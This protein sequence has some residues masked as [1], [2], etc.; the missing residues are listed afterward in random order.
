ML[1]DNTGKELRVTARLSADERDI[2]DMVVRVFGQSVCGF[3][4]LRGA[5][6]SFICDVNGW[7]FV[8]NDPSYYANCSRI[9]RKQFLDFMRDRYT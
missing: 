8:K 1:R 7:S 6:G 4:L 3:D 5:Q 9:L 2:A